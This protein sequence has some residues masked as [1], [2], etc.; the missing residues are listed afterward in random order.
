MSDPYRS[1]HAE[2]PLDRASLEEAWHWVEVYGEMLSFWRNTMVQF[3]VWLG[4]VRS[5]PARR[6]L[7]DVDEAI[8]TARCERM[9][10]R[11]ALWALRARELTVLEARNDDGG[12]R[13]TPAGGG[14]GGSARLLRRRLRTLCEDLDEVLARVAEA[15]RQHRGGAAASLLF[16]AVGIAGELASHL[17]VARLALVDDAPPTMDGVHELD[18]L[19]TM[20]CVRIL[21]GDL[22]RAAQGEGGGDASL[23]AG[24]LL[25][26]IRTLAEAACCEDAAGARRITPHAAPGVTAG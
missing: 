1:M 7:H 17:S 24:E 5:E 14:G 16:D 26:S 20:V 23:R 19:R 15:I 25:A 2:P 9:E 8:L 4:S 13:V 18:V 11:L 22:Q 21:D 3:A 6:E 12:D 10:R